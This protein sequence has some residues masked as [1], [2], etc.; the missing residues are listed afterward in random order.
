MVQDPARPDKSCRPATART[1]IATCRPPGCPGAAGQ[2]ADLRFDAAGS[3]HGAVV[4]PPDR[5]ADNRTSGRAAHPA[6]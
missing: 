6:G 1:P 4:R 3:G 2:A 5:P